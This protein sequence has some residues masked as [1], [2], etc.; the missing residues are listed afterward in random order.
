MP[1][2]WWGDQ[3]NEIVA[4]QRVMIGMLQ[5]LSSQE[6]SMAVTLD[7]L[8]AEVTNNTNVTNSVIALLGNLTALIK[9]IP[10]SSD[11]VTQAALD[12]LTASLTTNDAAVAAA[13]TANTPAA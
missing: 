9:A 13:V 8:T 3:L 1:W 4:N 11:P 5:R 6:R 10:P 7:A 2:K 12:A